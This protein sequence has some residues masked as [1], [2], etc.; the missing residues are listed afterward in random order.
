MAAHRPNAAYQLFMFGNWSV[1][2]YTY[3]ETKKHDVDLASEYP[4][5][6]F[7]SALHF[8]SQCIIENPGIWPINR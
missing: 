2:K 1:S 6:E 8:R 4:V 7:S 3:I 5:F